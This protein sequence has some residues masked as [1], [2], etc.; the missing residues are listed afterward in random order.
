MPKTRRNRST[1]KSRKNRKVGGF[2]LFAKKI[3]PANNLKK[4]MNNL[5]AAGNLPT[6]RPRSNTMVN[7]N[8]MGLPGRPRSNTMTSKN[9]M[10]LPG[11]PR[12][13]TMTS[14]NNIGLP[15]RARSETLANNNIGL[16]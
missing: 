9:N 7:T 1:R 3:S 10:G 11:R 5:R 8:N 14:N 2:E 6:G 4:H 13:N 12:S 15:G 16:P